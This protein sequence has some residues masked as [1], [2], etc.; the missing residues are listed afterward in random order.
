MNKKNWDPELTAEQNY[1]LKNEGTE[2]AGSSPLNNEK[3]EGD[4]L[5][6]GC[7]TRLFTSSTKYE[8][9]S[10]WPS[11]FDSLPNVFETK[12][13]F[14]IGYS[15]TEYH[16]KNCGGHHGHI[17]NDGPEPTGKRYCNNGTALVFKPKKQSI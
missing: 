2:P 5:C 11:F 1:I 8:S 13:D 6:A 15:R 7:G 12:K 4:Y 16:C 17:F 3:R 10:G 9:G 14:N